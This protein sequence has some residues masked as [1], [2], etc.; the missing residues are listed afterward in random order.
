MRVH[1]I[2]VQDFAGIEHYRLE[3]PERGVVV[4]E[5]PNEAGKSTL[6]RALD[7][8]LAEKDR[9]RNRRVREAQ[10]IGRD[11]GPRVSAELTVGDHRFRYTKQW[12][13][14]VMTELHISEPRTEQLSGDQAHE[15]VLGLLAEHGD[16]S[17]RRVLQL[18]QEGDLDVTGLDASR[19]LAAALDAAAG[20][21]PADDSG[22]AESLLERV[23]TEYGRYW[24]ARRGEATGELATVRRE[25]AAAR[26]RE[27][28]AR[29]AVAEVEGEVERAARLGEEEQ[30]ARETAERATER[31][32]G[33]QERWAAT[34]AERAELERAREQRERAEQD[35]QRA[36]RDHDQRVRL[37]AEAERAEQEQERAAQALREAAEPLTFVEE[38]LREAREAESSAREAEARARAATRSAEGREAVARAAAE[39]AS[40]AETVARIEALEEKQRG[41]ERVLAGARVD[42]EAL[43]RITAAEDAVRAAVAGRDAASPRV[44]ITGDPAGEVRVDGSVVG[45]VDLPWGAT[46][47]SATVIEHQGLRVRVV[48][49]EGVDDSEVDSARHALAKL[50]E[51]LGAESLT[52]AHRLHHELARAEAEQHD[53]AARLEAAR[54]GRTLSEWRADAEAAAALLAQADEAARGDSGQSGADTSWAEVRAALEEA[55]SEEER[56]RQAAAEATARVAAR[57]EAAGSRREAHSR[58]EA[59][60][61]AAQR[62]HELAAERLAQE[63][64]DRPDEALTAAVEELE[65]ELERAAE[66]ETALVERLGDAGPSLADDL[67]SARAA[68]ERSRA[69]LAEAQE[70][71]VRIEATL[72]TL[73]REG[74]A[75]DLSAAEAE[76]EHAAAEAAR[77]EAR[78][79]AVQLLRETLHA[80][81]SEAQAS[82]VRPF[83]EAVEELGAVLHGEGFAVEVAPDLT[84]TE[85]TL[86]GRP[87]PVSQLSTGAR[88]QLAVLTRLAVAR[89]VDPVQGV[90]VVLDDALGWTD[91][92][93]LLRMGR[94][95][96]RAGRDSQVLVLTCTPGRYD[97]VPSAHVV[98]IDELRVGATG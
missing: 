15:R 17:L 74:R 72:E 48:P 79:A 64:Q 84:I 87:V 92:N 59:A 2:E 51:E 39:H 80:R 42:G 4:L 60:H 6:V 52:D 31:W 67:E 35:L 63:R 73:G 85:R 11:V 7:M 41:I 16:E 36:R 22:E 54:A 50:L 96:E 75:E 8:L 90:P 65:Q 55:R 81:R 78:A 32:A 3:L 1:S 25:L 13:R 26:E 46:V 76:L 30:R 20:G 37:I 89:V 93:R 53:L 91:P 38:E 18:V 21:D 33:L 56:R 23:E 69:R 24:T 19:T 62:S 83:R 82:Y 58:A 5:G 71:R 10:P 14:G 40:L 57:Q 94:A 12:L 97:G 29:T 88:E 86:G 98:R 77:V 27:S 66:Q 9:G 68:A 28:A 47:H 43:R 45:S 49:P 44:E 34:E 61:G 95:L 70:A